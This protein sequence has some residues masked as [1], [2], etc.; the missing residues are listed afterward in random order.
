[1][2][3]GLNR[4]NK[5]RQVEFTFSG[6]SSAASSRAAS[7]APL[8]P[9]SASF[10]EDYLGKT[11]QDDPGC[12]PMDVYDATLPPWRAAVRRKLVASIR[13]ESVI[14]A[15]MQD[16]IRTPWL[17]TYFVHSSA[18]GTHTFFMTFL[19]MLFFFGYDEL[20][21][22]LITVI[23]F[24][25]YFTSVV[26]DLFCSPRPF[27]PPVTRMTIGTHHLEYGMPSTHSA[28]SVSLAL[29]FFAHIHDLAFPIA[30]TEPSLSLPAYAALTAGLVI[31]VTS[32]VF[33]RLY[34]AMHSFSDCAVG[35]FLG[36]LVW[37]AHTSFRGI[38]VE[39][40]FSPTYTY[41]TTLMRGWGWGTH[42][43]AWVLRTP[44][45]LRVPL[46]VIPLALLAVNQHPQ[47]VDD[48]PCFEDAIA[49]GSVMLGM[50]VG[51][52]GAVR[53]ALHVPGAGAVM[54]GS[55]WV[56]GAEGWTAV[57]RGWGDVGV[58]WG[59]ATLKMVF[60]IAV[61]FAWRLL[62]KAILHRALPPTFRFL[63]TLMRL[64]H[65]RFYTPAT[66]YASGPPVTALRPIP[67]V[68][69]LPSTAGVEV[70]GIGS[71]SGF[72]GGNE[73]GGLRRRAEAVEAA[74][75]GDVPGVGMDG[76]GGD[77]GGEVKHYDADVLTKLIVYAGIAVI[78]LEV[79]PVLFE[80]F[81][82]GVRSRP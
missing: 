18:L 5:P 25:I 42:L 22:G 72:G 60:G 6:P 70:G 40:A 43:D 33:G 62:V 37:L 3:S 61:I 54:P 49:I 39:L 51:R 76:E 15:K 13:V 66:E 26:K 74:R 14:V 31:Y 2:T 27:A 20:G 28:N 12:R 30:P 34:T 35:V 10:R 36:A 19:P 24:G 65:R 69:D 73:K 58:W 32:I 41:T 80:R 44:S 71:G 17:D 82:W 57:E 46:T 1:M 81:G 23:C 16:A 68:I 38:P 75:G 63:A 64:P 29:F 59:A 21:R 67:S 11:I 77:E 4:P 8:T 78:A 56:L 9:A 50:L 53:W 45:S 47:P 52:W 48:C 55:G 7:P 79:M